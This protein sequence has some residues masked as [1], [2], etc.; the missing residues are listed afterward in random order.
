M[1]SNHQD[2][3][4]RYYTEGTAAR[5]IEVEQPGR[6]SHSPKPRKKVKVR[7]ITV[8]PVAIGAIVLS[9]VMLVLMVNAASNLKAEQLRRQEMVDYLF[10]LE[11]QNWYDNQQYQQALNLEEVEQRAQVLGLIPVEE[12][13]HITVSVDASR[14]LTPEEEPT[15]WEKLLQYLQGLFA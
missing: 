7:V 14:E 5:K 13:T 1:A 12:A 3:Y 4:I 8:D 10:A 2:R 11:N 9:I 6:T 15:W